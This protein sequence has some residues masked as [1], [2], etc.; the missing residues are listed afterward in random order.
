MAALNRCYQILGLPRKARL[1]EVK[2]AFRELALRWHPDH[3]PQDPAAQVRFRKILEAYEAVL[4]HFKEEDG[5]RNRHKRRD[6]PAGEPWG[7]G[8]TAPRDGQDIFNEYFGFDRHHRRSI[9]SSHYDLRFDLQVS[10]QVMADGGIESI[11]YQRLVFCPNC[12]GPGG[13][14][15]SVSLTCSLCHGQGEM[16]EWRSILVRIP[17][18]SQHGTRLR[19]PLG[20]DQLQTGDPAGDLIILLLLGK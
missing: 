6:R 17:A 18:G 2:K 19:I 14:R 1:E 10:R 4:D 11:D 3:N 13:M 20:G 12:S 9:R 16:E 8:E 5:R 7:S 15:A